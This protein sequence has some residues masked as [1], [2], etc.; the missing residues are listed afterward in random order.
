MTLAFCGYLLLL[1]CSDGRR[2]HVSECG[3]MWQQKKSTSC[4]P[5]LLCFDVL[6]TVLKHAVSKIKH[7]TQVHAVLS[8]YIYVQ[9]FCLMLFLLLIN[10]SVVSKICAVSKI[11]LYTVWL[12]LI[13]SGFSFKKKKKKT[14]CKNFRSYYINCVMKTKSTWI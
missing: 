12:L 1:A 2:S 7:V 14:R 11:T 10:K 9:R 4:V 8:I 3:G 6:Q 13:F 5:K